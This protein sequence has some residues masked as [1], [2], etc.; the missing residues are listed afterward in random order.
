MISASLESEPEGADN[1]RRALNLFRRGHHRQAEIG[2][3][4]PLS[5]MRANSPPHFVPQLFPALMERSGMPWRLQSRPRRYVGWI[6]RPFRS[7]IGPEEE[8]PLLGTIKGKQ[9]GPSMLTHIASRAGLASVQAHSGY[10]RSI[11]ET[12]RTSRGPLASFF[13]LAGRGGSAPF[14]ERWAISLH[15]GP[16]QQR[17]R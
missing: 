6:G 5:T 2:R 7:A 11:S 1:G 16:R 4:P 15:K 12:S 8:G 3:F 17:L 13:P 10:R 14:G 9:T